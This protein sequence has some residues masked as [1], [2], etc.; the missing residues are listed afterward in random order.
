MSGYKRVY[1]TI[2][3]SS[4]QNKNVNTWTTTEPMADMNPVHR[5]HEG[6]LISVR[7]GWCTI[8]LQ[9]EYEKVHLAEKCCWV[10][11]FFSVTAHCI[12][13]W[14]SCWL[15][16][17]PFADCWL[18]GDSSFIFHDMSWTPSVV[19]LNQLFLSVVLVWRSTTLPVFLSLLVSL[20]VTWIRCVRS[21]RTKGSS[22]ERTGK[23]AGW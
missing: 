2:V 12:S 17:F 11:W 9:S 18:T 1:F 7:E 20:L 8:T 3:R 22:E 19:V 16:I 21:I 6:L 4:H 10:L 14:V 23:Q 15:L 5:C 13:P